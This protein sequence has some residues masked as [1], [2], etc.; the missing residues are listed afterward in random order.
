M[1]ETASHRAPSLRPGFRQELRRGFARRPLVADDEVMLAGVISGVLWLT[2]G[3]TLLPI[4]FF[5]GVPHSHR[6]LLGMIAA[7]AIAVGAMSIRAINWRRL[8]VWCFHVSALAGLAVVAVAV[9]ASGGAVSPAWI[10]LLFIALFAPYFFPIPVAIAYLVLCVLVHGL[11]LLYDA[12]A[13]DAS[14]LAQWLLGGSFYWV[15]GGAMVSGKALMWM[16]RRQAETFAIQERALRAVAT[17]VVDGSDEAAIY[18]LVA[19]EV[20]ELLGGGAAGIMR[21]DSPTSS[22]VMGSWADH[23]QGRY[24]PGTVV[25][26]RPGSDVE[27][28]IRTGRPVRVC[29]HP[30]GSPVRRLGYAA[31]IVAPIHAGGTTWGVLAVTAASAVRLTELDE[32]RLLAFGDLLATAITSLEDRAKLAAQAS[33]DPLTGL[34]NHRVL[35]ERLRA[36]LPSD[37]DRPPADLA[38]VVLDI[39]HFKQFNDVGGHELGDE[40]LVRVADCLRRLTRAEDVLGRAGGDE[41]TWI[42]PGVTSQ[43]ALE[44]VEAARVVIEA[45]ASNPYRVTVSAGICDTR[46]TADPSELIRL[47]DGAL[48]WSKA[49]GRDQCQ[50][51]DPMVIDELS[52][53]DRAERLARS[54]ALVG[55]RA[56]ARAIDAKDPDTREHSERVAALAGELARLAGWPRDRARLLSEAALVHD[57]GK[58]GV[59]DAIL[60]KPGRLTPPE[61]AQ[62]NLHAELSARIVEGVLSDEQVQWIRTHHERPDG[63]GY[64]AGLCEPEIPEGGCLLSIA[65][66]F[67]VMTAGRPYSRRR[68]VAEALEE[69]RSLTGQHFSEVAVTALERLVAEADRNPAAVAGPVLALAGR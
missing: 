16:H 27:Q 1:L 29:D 40:M 32:Q 30:A 7:A 21:I 28:T 15:L 37:P 10:Y 34:A 60:R 41:F 43:Q 64:P 54:Q 9:S 66:A 4:M 55:L 31:S 5:P 57:V 42:M 52:D 58:I 63:A 18:A 19:R 6:A 26:I 44:R 13:T 51:Y 65:D 68:S 20:A 22:T 49:H 12:R 45:T 39:D 11:P 69:C 23:P 38:V 36:L 8:P 62:V 17:A 48:Y 59:P 24:A 67:D 61:R 47:A 25:P 35:H 2:G 46:A 53:H 3:L 50:I 14:F 56:L 33:S